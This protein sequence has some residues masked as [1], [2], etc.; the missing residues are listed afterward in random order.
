MENYQAGGGGG[1]GVTDP[2]KRWVRCALGSFLAAVRLFVFDLNVPTANTPGE[3]FASSDLL[4][5]LIFQ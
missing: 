2:I 1:G 4:L 5:N 3:L